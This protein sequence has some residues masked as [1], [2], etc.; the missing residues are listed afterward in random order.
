MQVPAACQPKESSH[1]SS[2]PKSVKTEWNRSPYQKCILPWPSSHHHDPSFHGHFPMNTG[3]M[4]RLEA[5]GSMKALYPVPSL[6]PVT[7]RTPQT[8]SSEWWRRRRQLTPWCWVSGGQE[9]VQTSL[10]VS[11][12]IGLAVC[13]RAPVGEIHTDLLN[14]SNSFSSGS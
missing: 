6:S 3:D 14:Q 8:L 12:S 2:P 10:R 7:I 5:P 4:V 11:A 1:S 9:K 13:V